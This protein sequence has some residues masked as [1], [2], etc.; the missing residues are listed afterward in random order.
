MQSIEQF[1]PEAERVRID[2]T[3]VTMINLNLPVPPDMSPEEF[4]ASYSSEGR[5][6]RDDLNALVADARRLAQGWQP[7][8]EDLLA[9][10]LLDGWRMGIV[11]PTIA[12]RGFI[13]GHP[14]E[15]DGSGVECG[16]VLVFQDDAIWIR[17]LSRFY[18]LGRHADDNGWQ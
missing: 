10:P 4:L 15:P 13:S 16:P 18:R 6:L 3:G 11:D 2:E 8:N 1:V 7:S 14:T 9:S 12:I 17:T 5:A